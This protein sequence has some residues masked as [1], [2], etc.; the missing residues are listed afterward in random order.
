MTF[1]NSICQ[2]AAFLLLRNKYWII[3]NDYFMFASSIVLTLVLAFIF[4]PFITKFM[5][6]IKNIK[7]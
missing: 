5:A 2:G 4:K 3:Q 7:I 6:Y 1:I